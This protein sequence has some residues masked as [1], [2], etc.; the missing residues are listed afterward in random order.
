MHRLIGAVGVQ[1]I[2][3]NNGIAMG[4]AGCEKSRRPRVQGPQSSRQ[5]KLLFQTFFAD[6]VLSSA[7]NLQIVTIHNCG[8]LEHVV[9][10]KVVQ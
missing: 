6:A 5:K 7:Q 3:R 1:D 2:G 9:M 10:K 4:R 8:R